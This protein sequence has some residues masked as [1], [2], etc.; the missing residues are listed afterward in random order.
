MWPMAREY[1]R[2]VGYGVAALASEG[3][4]EDGREA[5]ELFGAASGLVAS[6][7]PH[8]RNAMRGQAEVGA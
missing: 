2:V 1:A 5:K 3:F 6:A 4:R 8:V 7:W